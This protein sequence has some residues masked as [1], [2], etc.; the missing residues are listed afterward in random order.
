MD[1]RVNKVMHFLTALSDC[2]K[3]KEERES[4]DFPG[5]KLSDDELTDDFTSMLVAQKILY[6]RITEDKQDLIGFTHIL[7]RLAFQFVSEGHIEKERT[8]TDE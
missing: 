3:E 1:K 2:Y 7:N 8:E 4:C 5:L 6:E